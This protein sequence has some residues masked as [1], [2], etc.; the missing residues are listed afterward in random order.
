MLLGA[1][2]GGRAATSPTPAHIMPPHNREQANIH[3][4]PHTHAPHQPSRTLT[5]TPI[6]TRTLTLVLTRAQ[7][8]RTVIEDDANAL[9]KLLVGSDIDPNS[10]FTRTERPILHVA[11]S[12]GAHDCLCYLIRLGADVNKQD[13]AG[14]T[15]LHLAARNGHR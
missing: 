14:R 4:L 8:H 15:A 11:A 6:I 1:R 7:L 2:A 3:S 13:S 5:H 9:V 10:T 12:L